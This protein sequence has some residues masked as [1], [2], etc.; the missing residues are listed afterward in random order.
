ME[1]IKKKVVFQIVVIT[2]QQPVFTKITDNQ[3]DYRN[4]NANVLIH[5]TQYGNIHS[6]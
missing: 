2:Y 6:H 4:R 1:S 3:K 5:S